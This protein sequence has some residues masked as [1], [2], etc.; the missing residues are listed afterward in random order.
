MKRFLPIILNIL[1]V[2]SAIICIAGFSSIDSHFVNSDDRYK[3][4]NI[5]YITLV[6]TIVLFIAA[7]ILK[8][9][10]VKS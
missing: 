9:K 5:F 10:N 8:K 4:I 7:K 3:T 1:G 6:S 2:I